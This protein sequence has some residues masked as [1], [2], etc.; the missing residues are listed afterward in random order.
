MKLLLIH[1]PSR[2]V[3]DKFE[4]KQ[5]D[6]M[7][8]GLAYIAAVGEQKGW[9]V[10]I[11]DAEAMRYSLGDIEREIS[12]LQP[13]VI[14]ITCTTP[15]YPIAAKIAKIAKAINPQ[16]KTILGG[17]HINAM[18]EDSLSK[19]PMVDIV[20][21]GEGEATFSELLDYL[22]RGGMKPN[23]RGVGYHNNKAIV[24]NTPRSSIA[25]LDSI[26]F[27]ARHKFPIE[28]YYDPDR[29]NTPYTL[30]VTSRGC[31]YNCIFC[32]SSVTWG[33]HIRFRSADNVLNEI[34]EVIN[35]FGIHNIT[36]SDDTFT[37]GK[38]RVID[39]CKGIIERG[40]DIEFLCSSR[41]NTID[42]KRLEFLAE[43]GCKEISFGVESG[44]EEILKTISKHIDLNKVKPV[45]DMVKS[46]GIKVH[47]SYIIGNPGDTHETIE[48]TINFAIE[49]G[50]DAAQFSISTPYPGTTLWNMALKRH[51][52]KTLNF[53]EYKWY[54]SVVAN[55]SE[56]SDE[57]LIDYQ[58]EAY[59]R[60][61][62]SRNASVQNKPK[63]LQLKY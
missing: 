12:R 62:R 54:Y 37:L 5:I 51:K 60:F 40:Y 43:A 29:Y 38:K 56:V 33:H 4:R 61:E 25:D 14:G 35:K 11:I 2:E 47:S 59:R 50:T 19:S 22:K 32:G 30:M 46:F 41:I 9:E 16:I 20:V 27:P 7:P 58:R 55:L 1:P 52:L 48:K 63:T 49:S 23:I 39:I 53:S 10:E 26:P 3:Y 13:D 57:D 17:P 34:G 28:K 15:L 24:L 8:I 45:F 18:P 42:E 21:F 44:D 36:F 31:P 6:R